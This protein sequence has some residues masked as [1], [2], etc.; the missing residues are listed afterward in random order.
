MMAHNPIEAVRVKAQVIN[1]FYG[2]SN[3]IHVLSVCLFL[4]ISHFFFS[5]LFLL[6]ACR[7]L[8]GQSC[9]FL[10]VM[11]ATNDQSITLIHVT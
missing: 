7:L 4:I 8:L 3:C 9:L 11:F 1:L 5:A 2:S 10:S 6:S